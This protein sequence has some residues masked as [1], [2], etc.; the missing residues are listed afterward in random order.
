M[1]IQRRIHN[2]KR[3]GNIFFDIGTKKGRASKEIIS[4]FPFSKKQKNQGALYGLV[5]SEAE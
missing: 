4:H 1:V 2:T 3:K 5:S